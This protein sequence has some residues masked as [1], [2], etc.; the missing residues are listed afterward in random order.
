MSERTGYAEIAAHYR[1]QIQ[2]GALSPGDTMPSL[3]EVCERFNV[4]NT[5]ANRA[6]RVLK[7]EGL[8]L[9]K[10][11][12]GT[13]VAG[14]ISNN[15]ATR[16]KLHESTG[17]ALGGGETSRITEVGTVG[18][19]EL[20]APRL[21]VAPGTPVHVRRRVV[22]RNG[23][24]VHFSSSYYPAY[25]IAVTPELTEPVSTG[26][27]RELAA[28]RLGSAQAHVLEEVTARFATETEKSALGL[29]AGNVIVNQVVRTVHLADGRVVEVAVKIAGGTTI[30]RWEALLNAERGAEQ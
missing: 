28:E 17:K 7:L 24:P 10:A 9:P 13:V 5:T 25:V 14:P 30:L 12:V 29:T 6:Y 26:G 15:I 18:A 23:A 2:D 16:V 27:S 3:R 20:V 19:D 22:S 21:D 8:T 4:A 1:Q 11:G